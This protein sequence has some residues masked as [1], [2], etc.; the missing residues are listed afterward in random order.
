MEEG[1]NYV[2]N[3]TERGGGWIIH[4]GGVDEGL[5]CVERN[6]ILWEMTI[7]FFYFF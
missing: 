1:S 2:G 6:R 5:C 7:I 4:G 3:N